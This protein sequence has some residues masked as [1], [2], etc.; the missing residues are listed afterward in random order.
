MMKGVNALITQTKENNM[1]DRQDPKTEEPLA[2]E[3]DLEQF[4]KEGKPPPHAK[5]YR[6][7]VD[8]QHYIVDRPKL[9]GREILVTAG[10]VPPEAFILTLKVRGRGVRTIAL[11][12]TVDLREPGVER[13]TTL[14]REVQEGGK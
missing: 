6:I 8:D 9:T 11:D 3:V 10:K 4:A 12:E 5:R 7:R 1:A 13:F 14:P 2:E